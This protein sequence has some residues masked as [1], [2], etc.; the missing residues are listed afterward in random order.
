[1]KRSAIIC[2]LSTRVLQGDR[3]MIKCMKF[4]A[5]MLVC[6]SDSFRCI[7]KIH[8]ASMCMIA[9]IMV[10]SII[11]KALKKQKIL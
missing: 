1:M 6:M 3:D 5:N 2:G 4:C 11:Q 10:F 8:A 9:S 7:K